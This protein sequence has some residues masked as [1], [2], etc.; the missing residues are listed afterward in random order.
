MAVSN[1]WLSSHLL[2]VML[3]LPL[4]W[5]LL[6]LLIP[7]GSEGGRGALRNW[8]LLGSILTFAVSV[9]VYRNFQAAG[10]DFQMTEVATWI[11]GLGISYNLGI[12]GISLWLVMLTTFLMPI[13]IAGSFSAI[14]ERVREYY[15]L[16]L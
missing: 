6:G 7:T 9:L 5:A 4:A 13:A 3:F 12:D 15:F 11:P 8:T 16:L 2:S 1:D 10:A 14:E